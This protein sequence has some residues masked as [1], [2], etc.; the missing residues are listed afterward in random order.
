LRKAGYVSPGLNTGMFIVAS[1]KTVRI[2]EEVE[3]DTMFHVWA[4]DSDFDPEH[5][6]YAVGYNSMFKVTAYAL[7]HSLFVALF[8]GMIPVEV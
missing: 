1:E 4:V 6:K 7:I 5:D 2:L 8:G 3:D